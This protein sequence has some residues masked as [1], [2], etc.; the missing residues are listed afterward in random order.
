MHWMS[1]PPSAWNPRLFPSRFSPTA[2]ARWWPCIV[3]ELHRPQAD[4]ILGVVQNLNQ[5]H[6]D[7]PEARRTIDAGLE[8]LRGTRPG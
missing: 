7:L 3:G 4:L 5:D 2:A 6:V 1:P 8:A